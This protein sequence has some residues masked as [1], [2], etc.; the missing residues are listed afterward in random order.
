MKSNK[1]AWRQLSLSNSN[2]VAKEQGT[3]STNK[4]PC[5]DVSKESVFHECQSR[6][7][8]KGLKMFGHVLFS[9]P[10]LL[11]Y[12]SQLFENQNEGAPL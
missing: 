11:A 10:T 9:P 1:E 12:L 3:E 8:Q 4:R 7:Q 6:N 5:S 2:S